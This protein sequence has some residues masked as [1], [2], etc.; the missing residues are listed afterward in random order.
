MAS[1]L[2]IITSPYRFQELVSSM[3][4]TSFKATRK[5]KKKLGNRLFKTIKIY[6]HNYSLIFFHVSDRSAIVGFQGPVLLSSL[7]LH[8]VLI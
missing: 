4:F 3:K 5:K 1:R 8:T 6:H 2:H 7:A